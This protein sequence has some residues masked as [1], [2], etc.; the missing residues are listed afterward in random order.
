[1]AKGDR[2]EDQVDPANI[3]PH[4]FLNK[5]FTPA[6]NQREARLLPPITKKKNARARIPT[7]AET[8]SKKKTRCSICSVYGHNKS[9][10]PTRIEVA[11][12]NA[13]LAAQAQ[14][15]QEIF[16]QPGSSSQ[17]SRQSSPTHSIQ[18]S[19]QHHS[20]YGYDPLRVTAPRRQYMSQEYFSQSIIV[21]NFRQTGPKLLYHR[22]DMLRTLA[23]RIP[24][25]KYYRLTCRITRINHITGVMRSTPIPHATVT[26]PPPLAIP[27]MDHI[28]LTRI[29]LPHQGSNR[30][31]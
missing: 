15:Q 21:H 22:P 30:T 20:S 28:H 7:A 13:R 18:S 25:V 26:T 8:A 5:T 9:K 1:M 17:A 23:I 14:Q 2:K 24:A 19:S 6:T 16:S 3:H 4:W 11:N 10:C 29:P 27:S 31:D 12:N